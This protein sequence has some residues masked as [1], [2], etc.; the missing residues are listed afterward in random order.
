MHAVRFYFDFISPYAYLAWMRSAEFAQRHGVRFEPRPVV[1][2]ALLDTHGL[3]GP[4]EV[5]TKRR[6]T[7]L[8]V[9]RTARTLDIPFQSVPAHPFRS[10]EAL[11][12]ACAFLHSSHATHLI[13][14]IY[15]AGWGRSQDLTDLEVL[16][17]AVRCSGVLGSEA[18]C[19]EFK[20]PALSGKITSAEVKR[21]LRANT[22]E[23]I[24]GGVFGVPTFEYQGELFWGEDRLGALGARLSGQAPPPRE[25]VE[26]ILAR[27]G[28][29]TRPKAP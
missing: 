24:A 25:L 20:G 29:A 8:D 7:F 28:Q 26:A 16:A 15:S 22:E 4:G 10:I 14:E 12:T 5:A 2:A 27:P 13:T 18:S 17:A 19:A 3:V 1:Y 6:Y 9:L 21:S 23:A 11:R